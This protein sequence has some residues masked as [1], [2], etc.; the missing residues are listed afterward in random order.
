MERLDAIIDEANDD[1]E[2]SSVGS[3]E[4]IEVKE[5][6][7]ELDRK[8]IAH[9]LNVY[10]SEMFRDLLNR[11]VDADATHLSLKVFAEVSSS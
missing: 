11:E 3:L 6:D 2:K 5:T 9:A 4:L 7:P 1:S 8:F 10:L